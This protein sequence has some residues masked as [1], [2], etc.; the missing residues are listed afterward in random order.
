[1]HVRFEPGSGPTM[2][3]YR[4][5][6]LHL[7]GV[8]N[9]SKAHRNYQRQMNGD[10]DTES[11]YAALRERAL[12]YLRSRNERVSEEELIRFLFGATTKPALWSSLFRTVMSGDHRFVEAFSGH[13]S[14][15]S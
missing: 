12:D 9:D 4:T 11:P 6:I 5:G 8:T 2:F 7:P 15:A 3:Q 13:W 14:L 1:M 10:H